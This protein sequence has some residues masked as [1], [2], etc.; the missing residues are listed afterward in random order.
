M[1]ACRITIAAGEFENDVVA[2]LLADAPLDLGD[3]DVAQRVAQRGPAAD[4]QFA[5]H[6]LKAAGQRDRER[7]D[8]N[9]AAAGAVD[10]VTPRHS[11]SSV[12]PR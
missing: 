5:V 12:E 8:R 6:G 9:K 3:L 1:G 2:D 11:R 10:P 4:G 7:A